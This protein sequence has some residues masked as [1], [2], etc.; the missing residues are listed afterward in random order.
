MVKAALLKAV[1]GSS[2]SQIPHAYW[3]ESCFLAH[4]CFVSKGVQRLHTALVSLHFFST[5]GNAQRRS[6]LQ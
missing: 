4:R 1:L 5:A 2:F 6:D 3:L